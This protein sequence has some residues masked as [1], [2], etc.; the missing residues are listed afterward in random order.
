MKEKNVSLKHAVALHIRA[1]KELHKV[2][3]QYIPTAT[4]T[5][6][7]DALSPYITIYFAARILEELALYRRETILW[8]LI[9]VG[10]LCTGSVAILNA[11]LRQHEEALLDDLWGRKNMLFSQKLFS[12]DF[13]DID[14]QETH[15]LRAQIQQSENWSG[16]GLM[17]A[18]EYYVKILKNMAGV[19][20]GVVL[21]AGLFT[22]QVPE[23]AGKLLAL[24]HPIFVFLIVGIMLFINFL[25]GNLESR[26]VAYWGNLGEEAT[27]GNRLFGFF[28][29]IG[30]TGERGA[31]IRMYNQQELVSFYWKKNSAF[32]VDG[33]IGKLSMGPMGICASLGVSITTMFT[34]FVYV[35][36][37]LKA[38]VGAFDVGAVT[39]YVGAVT[40]LS[41][42]VF[43]LI[44]LNGELKTNAGY[45][46]KTFEFL[47]IP[48]SMYQGSLTTEKRSDRQYEVEFK[49]VFFKY[50]G[51]ENWALK[52]V[53]MKFK[54]GS[55]LA[56]V[57]ENGS[58]KTTFIKL[59]C[60]LYDPQEG[61]ILLNGIDIRKYNYRDYMDIFSIVFQDFQLLSQPLGAN[62]AGNVTYDKE[63]VTKALIDAGFGERLATMPDG[64]DTQL[65]KEFTENG[66]EISGGEAQKI[67]IARALYKDASFI[68]LDEPTAAL[69]PIAEA[70]IYSKFN[71]IS[72]DKTAIYISH[73]LSSCK[74]CDEIAVF[75]EGSVI[76]KGT[77]EG[78]LADEGGKYHELWHAQAQYYTDNVA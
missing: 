78:L 5:A 69:D 70:E 52:N 32:G 7:V 67:A 59:L 53:S 72:G 24:N 54:V 26:A 20:S 4:A 34:G 9:A 43:A 60:R 57:G 50:P 41:A 61:Q 37:C 10:V 40:A 16:W 17:R 19:F 42:N 11:A 28:G 65:Y 8:E 51:A 22:A 55:R 66:V 64:L 35:F 12:M 6:I 31:D 21:T 3:P 74:F 75:H 68:I 76:Q 47:D 30:R 36:T 15:D 45:L 23:T 46:K 2:T 58:G 77:H 44:E 38:W 25:A 18:P 27:F 73:R 1:M 29:F 14:K 71:D 49:N 39:Q 63:K 33:K 13:A 56:I 62:V 48:N